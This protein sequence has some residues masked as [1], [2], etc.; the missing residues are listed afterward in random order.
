MNRRNALRKILFFSGISA[1]SFSGYNL[2]KLYRAPNISSLDDKRLLIASLANTIIPETKSPGAH[3]AN[4]EVLIIRMLKNCTSRKSLN[5][6]IYG[7]ISVERLCYHRYN[8]SF[9][10]CSETL[11]VEILSSLEKNQKHYSIILGKIKKKI[12]GETFI[13]LLKKYTVI[14]YCTSKSGATEG[15]AYNALPGKYVGCTRL[16]SNQKSWATN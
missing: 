11:R 9:I 4:V 3:T 13:S 16:G 10:K 12:L 2:F 6:F 14:G 8:K 7:L 5:N 15:L 1:F